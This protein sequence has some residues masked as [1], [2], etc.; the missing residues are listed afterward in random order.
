MKRFGIRVDKQYFNFGSAH[1]IL[2]EDGTR[3]ELHGHN[4]HVSVDV[5][6]ELDDGDV[7]LDFI[8]FKPI[9]KHCCDELDHKLLLP[10][11]NPWLTIAKSDKEL[12]VRHGDDRF[13]GIG[14]PLLHFLPQ[15]AREC[16]A[17]ARRDGGARG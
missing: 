1:F 5:D 16:R 8:P 11:F 9:V 2:F 4:Y 6:G 14:L 3:E 15:E 13:A 12:E 7:V 17:L 10:Q